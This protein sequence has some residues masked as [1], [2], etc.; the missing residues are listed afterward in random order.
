[1]MFTANLSFY[2]FAE[3]GLLMQIGKGDALVGGVRFEHHFDK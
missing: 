1:M 2:R 3:S